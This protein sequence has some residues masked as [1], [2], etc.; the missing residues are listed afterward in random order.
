MHEPLV[1]LIQP[2]IHLV[3]PLIDLIQP[4]IHL[5]KPLIDLIEPLSTRSNR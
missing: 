4:P 2:P 1:D 5:V 3:N